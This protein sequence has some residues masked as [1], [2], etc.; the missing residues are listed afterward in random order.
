MLP[1]RYTAAGIRRVNRDEQQPVCIYF[2]PWEIDPYQ[3]RLAKGMIAR[4][5]TYTGLKGMRRK[6]ERL[7]TEFSFSTLTTV[8]PQ[9]TRAVVSA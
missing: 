5:R 3:P 7:L 1:Y 6:L 4:L 2:H 9:D 8:Y